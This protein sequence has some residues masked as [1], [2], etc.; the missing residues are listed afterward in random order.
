MKQIITKIQITNLMSVLLVVMFIFTGLQINAQTIEDFE[1]GDFSQYNWQFEGNT[2]WEISTDNPYEGTYCVKSGE[3]TVFDSTVLVL[4][5]DVPNGDYISFYA[6]WFIQDYTN[7]GNL[8]FFIDDEPHSSLGRFFDMDNGMEDWTYMQFYVE[9]GTHTFRWEFTGASPESGGSVQLDNITFP[10]GQSTPEYSEDFETG[11]FTN[12]NWVFEGNQDV[13]F[14]DETNYSGG[15]YS[16]STGFD[17]INEVEDNMSVTLDISEDGI[18]C[19]DLKLEAAAGGMKFRVDDEFLWYFFGN[20][21]FDWKTY[22]VHIKAG[23]HKFT[24]AIDQNGYQN[25]D[26]TWHTPEKFVDNIIFPGIVNPC[27]SLQASFEYSAHPEDYK[28]IYFIDGTTTTKP[29]STWAWDFGDGNISTQSNPIHTYVGAGTYNVCLTVTD[30]IGCINTYCEELLIEPHFT[31]G[32]TVFA[33]YADNPID[34]G[35]AYLYKMNDNQIEDVYSNFITD[36]GYYDFNSLLESDYI[37]KAELSPNSSYFGNYIPTYYGDVPDWVNA[38]VINLNQSIFDAN[39]NL[40]PVPPSMNGTG[41]ITG[42][43][44]SSEDGRAI[45][46]GVAI[47]L[48]STDNEL[49]GIDFTDSEGNFTLENLL[50]DSYKVIVEITGKYATPALI[51]LDDQNQSSEVSF[52]IEGD[53]VVLS[54]DNDLPA[55]VNY[56]SD[57]YPNPSNAS[58]QVNIDLEK[59]TSLK[60]KVYNIAGQIVS[61]SILETNF[62]MNTKELDISYLND[63]LYYLQINFDDKHS[64]TRKFSKIK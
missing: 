58:I 8:N 34:E 57:I 26:S 9:S 49:L 21:G 13:W 20:A 14:I 54:V 3:V 39:V 64:V 23:T 50:L 4:T 19:F 46:E 18:V 63:G 28:M 25:L 15:I 41:S 12:L 43:V 48:K 16:A 55:F 59:L 36:F 51:T 53:E 56:I 5:M 2:D 32:G 44:Y 1:T 7:P 35:F 30:E 24:W 40:I 33:Q 29:I 60:F 27:D 61:E 31:L 42:V 37:L 52:V 22:F 11:D 6:K 38:T 62:G 17:T 10:M 47:L 45:V